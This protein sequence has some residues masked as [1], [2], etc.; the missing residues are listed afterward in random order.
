MNYLKNKV[1]LVRK[2]NRGEKNSRDISKEIG[3]FFDSPE[4]YFEK[5]SPVTIGKKIN[6]FDMD[7]NRLRRLK[8]LKTQK[9]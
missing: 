8:K 5:N 2:L 1:L 7:D 9:E 4:K 6:I 3:E